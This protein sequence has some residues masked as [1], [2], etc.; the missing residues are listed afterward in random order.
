MITKRVPNPASGMSHRTGLHP[1]RG[2]LLGLMVL[3]GGC[4]L[5]KHIAIDSPAH[6]DS[7]AEWLKAKRAVVS[8]YAAVVFATYQD[9]LGTARALKFAVDY[10][11]THPSESTLDA[12]REAWRA[13]RVPYCQTEVFRFY[14]GPIDQIDGMVNAWPIDEN[15]L[16]YVAD[17]PDAGIIN[18]PEKCPAI[19]RELI[20]SL[21]EKEG[22]KNISTGFHAIEFLLWGQDQS[23]TG[24]GA[25]S[26]HDYAAPA[27]NFERRRQ[28]LRVTT[29]LLVEHLE[30]LAAAWAEG[31]ARNYRAEFV[32]DPDAALAKILRGMGA[33]SGPELAGERLTVPYETKE[34]EEEHSCFSDNTRDDIVN[35]AIGIRNVFYGCYTTVQGRRVSGPRIYDLLRQKDADFAERL[36]A[37]IESAVAAAQNIPQ[38]FDQAIRGGNAAMGRAAI[39]QAIAALQTE[40][41]MLAQAAKVLSIELAP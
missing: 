3:A 7:E 13:A 16:D 12:A 39:K 20:L 33:L 35:N 15:Y 32:A 14:D 17:N 28:C 22:T 9:S 29:D 21:N 1:L 25:R 2:A 5:Q 27:R 23:V 34:Q 41:D 6:V 26:W 19:S 8:N 38:P 18:T 30:S 10:F 24:P 4:N 36:A 37:Q 31:R 40:S 11:L